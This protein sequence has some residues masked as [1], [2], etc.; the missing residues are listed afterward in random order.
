[1]ANLSRTIDMVCAHLRNHFIDGEQHEAGLFELKDGKIKLITEYQEGQR[2]LLTGGMF[3][4]GSHKII[5]K[6]KSGDRFLY[7][8]EGLESV[9]DKLTIVYGQRVPPQFL[10][11]CEEIRGFKEAGGKPSAIVSESVAGFHKWQKATDANGRP[12]GWEAVFAEELKQYRR[13]ITGVS[14]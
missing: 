3:A 9:S 1:M 12:L 11:L 2:L 7:A 5:S 8:L 10:A 6:R 14:L 13:A 4:N